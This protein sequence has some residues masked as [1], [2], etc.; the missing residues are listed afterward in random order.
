MRLGVL[1]PEGSYGHKAAI[2]YSRQTSGR[3]L[4]FF[5]M[6]SEIIESVAEGRIEGGIV[7]VEHMISGTVRETVDPII[8]IGVKPRAQVT[9]PIHLC[10]AAHGKDFDKVYS[11]PVALFQ[12]MEHLRQHNVRQIPTDS[13]SQAFALASRDLK[14][15][16]IGDVS[17]AQGSGL[18]VIDD[19]IEDNEGNETRFLVIGREDSSLLPCCRTMLCLEPE[20]DWPGLLHDLLK[21]F[22]DH[23]VNIVR[24]ESRPTM[25]KLGTY[26]F[27][28]DLQGHR[29]EEHVMRAIDDARKIAKANVIGSYQ[30]L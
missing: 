8:E 4:V 6:H 12:C 19:H 26:F 9:I 3:E 13:T 23:G 21:P 30:V 14:A 5:P 15:A 11:H 2:E 18:Q 17:C 29:L 25:R 27:M 10:L 16:A 7:A 22:R 1:G 28:M 24:I 20:D